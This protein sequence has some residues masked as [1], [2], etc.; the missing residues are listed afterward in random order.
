MDP[1]ADPEGY[2]LK[3]VA[4]DLRRGPYDRRTHPLY[5]Y[6]R[7][8]EERQRVKPGRAADHAARLRQ[9]LMTHRMSEVLAATDPDDV[10]PENIVRGVRGAS[11]RA[12]RTYL[13]RVVRSFHA[14]VEDT[15]GSI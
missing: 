8:L 5:P 9:I 3:I 14:W 7:Y 13:R 6:M 10:I 15:G 11:R 1:F 2:R 12:D 4:H